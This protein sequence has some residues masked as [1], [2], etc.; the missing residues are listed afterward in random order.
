MSVDRDGEKLIVS[1]L[2]AKTKPQITSHPIKAINEQ[3]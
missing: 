1:H 2:K 3:I